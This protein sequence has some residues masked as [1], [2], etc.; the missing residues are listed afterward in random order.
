M[1]FLELNLY[2]FLRSKER[3]IKEVRFVDLRNEIKERPI[4]ESDKA[5]VRKDRSGK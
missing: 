1:P 2:K 3:G 5:E 4:K